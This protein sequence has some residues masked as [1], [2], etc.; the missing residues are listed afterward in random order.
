MSE[1]IPLFKNKEHKILKEA[2]SI[3]VK[4]NSESDPVIFDR[5]HPYYSSFISIISREVN[6]RQ[7][8]AKKGTIR[9]NNVKVREDFQKFRIFNYFNLSDLNKSQSYI[10]I[11]LFL[12]HF[13]FSGNKDL[14]SEKDFD[15]AEHGEQDWQHYII[16]R[17]N[18]RVKKFL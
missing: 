13:N 10:A 12:I 16:G 1:C 17:V 2:E 6:R 8:D 9:F 11:G 4:I 7:K 15:P 5:T 14:I 3:Q 18:S